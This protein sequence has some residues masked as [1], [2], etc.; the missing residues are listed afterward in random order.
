M[1]LHAETMKDL[2]MSRSDYISSIR[3]QQPITELKRKADKAKR[4]AIWTREDLDLA[5]AEAVELIAFFA[6]E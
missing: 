1:C 5:D 2:K 3:R 6:R 4:R